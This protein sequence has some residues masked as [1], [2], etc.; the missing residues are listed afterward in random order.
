MTVSGI[1]GDILSGGFSPASADGRSRRELVGIAVGHVDPTASVTI[2]AIP[3]VTGDG[4]TSVVVAVAVGRLN[5]DRSLAICHFEVILSLGR[6]DLLIGVL[7][8]LGDCPE[9]IGS[10]RRVVVDLDERTWRLD[11]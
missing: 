2:A 3:V 9:G 5:Y 8:R 1:E 10:G 7:L 4:G 6:A 11:V